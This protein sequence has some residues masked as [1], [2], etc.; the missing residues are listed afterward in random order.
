M[1]LMEGRISSDSAIMALDVSTLRTIF[2]GLECWRAARE[3]YGID[4][5]EW[6]GHEYHIMDIEALYLASQAYLAPRQ[7]QA[8]EHFLVGNL[9]EVDVA[10]MMGISP[11]NPIGMYASD[12]LAKLIEMIQNR[13]L[14]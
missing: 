13:E 4:T 8:I 3:D 2:K 6:E 14:F 11:T 1:T 10:N 7:S 9:R 12:G 5:I